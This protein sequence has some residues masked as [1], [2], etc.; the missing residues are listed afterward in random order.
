MSSNSSNS[1]SS[2]LKSYIDSA[3]GTAQSAIGA[4]TGNPAEKVGTQS[5]LSIIASS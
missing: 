5:L 4:V 3:V 2:T 1:N